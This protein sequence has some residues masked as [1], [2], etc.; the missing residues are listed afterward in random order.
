MLLRLYSLPIVLPHWKV[1]PD[2]TI[3]SSENSVTN[4]NNS[5]VD[6]AMLLADSPTPLEGLSR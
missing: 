3:G 5:D 4:T 2:N 1:F 6:A